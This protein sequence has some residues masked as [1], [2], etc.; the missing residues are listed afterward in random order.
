MFYALGRFHKPQDF[1]AARVRV[2]NWVKDGSNLLVFLESGRRNWP[3]TVEARPLHEDEV[4]LLEGWLD[5]A[6][7][8]NDFGGYA[9]GA[10]GSQ[11]AAL[12][13]FCHFKLD[14]P[15]T[16]ARLVAF[17]CKGEVPL[18]EPLQMAVSDLVR[19][20][21]HLREVYLPFFIDT[22]ENR[23]LLAAHD[24]AP[25]TQPG[26]WRVVYEGE[27]ETLPE[28]I[29]DE[30]A[31]PQKWLELSVTADP[32]A[33]E[34]ITEL[35]ARYGYNQGIAIEKKVLP[36][37]DSGAVVDESAPVTIRTYVLADSASVA[38]VEKVREGMFYLGQLRPIG[39]LQVVERNEEEWANAWKEFDAH[40]I[41]QRTVIKPPWQSYVPQPGDLIVEIDPGMAFGT[42]L[43]PTT[44]LCLVLLEDY[45]DP[46]T[47]HSLLDFGTGSGILAI[48][49]ARQG[50]PNILGLDADLIAVKSARENVA[51][52]G[53]S[54]QIQIEAGSLA[55][56]N[57]EGREGDFYAFSEQAQQIPPILSEKLPFDFITANIIARS[58]SA[59]AEPLAAALRPGGLLI[60]SGIIAEK[61]ERVVTAY[62]TAGLELVE[63]RDDGDW[64]AFL[65]RKI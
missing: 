47:H 57:S 45:L 43:H 62:R 44:S 37:A 4:Q 25:S 9:T 30:E 16:R 41:G 20:T 27:E 34:S 1:I 59:L 23:D 52:N 50:V 3:P 51:R 11:T 15:K 32:E 55:I 48:A 61:A 36:G 7:Q 21:P 17:L 64:V 53:L 46:T 13:G 58:L 56:E 63:R 22:P 2:L 10:D 29:E 5:D 60:S 54:R 6:W 19:E 28:L 49:A 31:P 42:G 14:E 65:H 33:V 40:R 18:L 26:W 12:T 8:Q 38:A 39:E 35:L 24:L